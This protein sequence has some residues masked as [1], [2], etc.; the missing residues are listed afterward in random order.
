MHASRS[1]ENVHTGRIGAR[2]EGVRQQLLSCGGVLGGLVE[3]AARP[4][5]GDALQQLNQLACRVAIVGQIKSGKSSFIN[6]FIRTPKLLPTAVT[7]WTTS[8]TNLHFRQAPP[9]GYAAVFRFMERDEWNDIAQGGGKIRELTERLVPGFEPELLQQQAQALSARARERLGS[10]FEQLLGQAHGFPT[11]DAETLQHYVCSGEF[12]PKK[13]IGKYSDITKTADIYLQQ[14]PFEFPCTLIDTPGTN[15]PFLI[16]DEITRRCLGSADVYVVVLTAR[17]PLSDTDVALLRMMRGLNK[18]RIIV[19]INRIDD[20]TD[21]DGE[22][23]QVITFVRER[24]A[25]EF[26]GSSIPV[27]YGS[28]WWATQAVAFELDAVARILKRPSAGYLLRAG[29]VQ[30][31][32][33]NSS[34]LSVPEVRDRIG[35]SLYVMSGLPA[36]YQAIDAMIG[37]TQPTFTLRQVTRSFAEMAR[38][39]ESGARSELQFLLAAQAS[40]Q[41]AASSEE[42]FA[43]Y[44]KERDLLTEVAK[45]IEASAA[46]IEAQLAKIIYEE[47]E[48]LRN[49]LM[50]T[51]EFHAGRE[52]DVL[53]DTLSRGRSPKVWTHEGVELRRALAHDFRQIFE[54]AAA[55]LTSFHARVVPELH[56]LMRSLVPQPD[57]AAPQGAEALAIP[58]PAVAPLSRMLVL[59][60]DDS[61]WSVFWSRNTS[62]ETSGAKIEELIRSEFKPVAD[63]LVQLAGRAFHSFGTTTVRWSF[64]AC[65]NIQHALRRRLELLLSEYERS[66]GPEEV[67]AKAALDDAVRGQALRLRDNETLTQHLETLANHL[68]GILRAEVRPA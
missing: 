27:V 8:V 30:P 34:S 33:L 24:L 63:E 65:R 23:N 49:T 29:L 58:A 4:L 48:R 56:E 54:T 37:T 32:E 3:P 55:R 26:P 7:P 39:C 36:V 62:A 64:G 41:E 11:L 59:D 18:D 57:L 60:L 1:G 31:Q 68:D 19:L 50:A 66:R 43:I 16:R 52:R 21:L 61:R 53:I 12:S 44:K 14:G 22:L 9:G 46:G 15:D 13:H 5:I 40:R 42:T 35:Q 20:L 2:L 17:Q 25:A 28:A 47:M 51:I 6:A 45:N 38:A 67:S 10:E